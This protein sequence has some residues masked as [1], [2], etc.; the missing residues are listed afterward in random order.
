MKLVKYDISVRYTNPSAKSD[1][2]AKV[3]DQNN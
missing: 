3:R 2:Q 1:G